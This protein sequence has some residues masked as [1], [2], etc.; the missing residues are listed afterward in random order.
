RPQLDVRVTSFR[1]QKVYVMGEVRKPGLQPIT[2]APLSITDAINLAGG[3]D[4]NSADT[5]N[6][7]II[8]GDYARPD[9]YWLNAKSPYALL[10]AE[11]FYLLPHDV[12]FV[13]ATGWSRWNRAISLVL[14]SIQTVW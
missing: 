4:Q 14:P 13:S 9:V 11:H 8:R 10:L 5:S 7:F 1:S 12:V 6:I 2:D 3:F